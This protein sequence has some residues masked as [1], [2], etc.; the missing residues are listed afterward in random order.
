MCLTIQQILAPKQNLCR[1]T[2]ALTIQQILPPSQQ[3]PLIIISYLHA[4]LG[5]AES[6]AHILQHILIIYSVPAFSNLLTHVSL[7]GR[8]PR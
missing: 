7:R 4:S 3:I 6:P 1:L 2:R 5:S 8:G